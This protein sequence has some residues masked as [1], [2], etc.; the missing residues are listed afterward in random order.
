MISVAGV[1][2]PPMPVFGMPVMNYPLTTL[3]QA[4]MA[5][6]VMATV[7][8]RDAV[9]C[10][11][12]REKRQGLKMAL[13]K[14]MTFRMGCIDAAVLK[15]GLDH[16]GEP[17]T[18]NPA[19]MTE[20]SGAEMKAPATDIPGGLLIEPLVHEDERGVFFETCNEHAFEQATGLRPHFVQDN[21]AV[22]VPN[23][24][25]GL[26]YQV[27]IRQGKLVRVVRG[28]VFDVVVDRRRASP[29]FGQAMT[30]VLGGGNRRQ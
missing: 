16:D 5:I 7:S 18:E 12:M 25:R 21:Q 26:H 8:L 10:R 29:A 9:R 20:L 23:A 17:V 13:P 19:A 3:M 6:P 22:P 15:A 28:A 24:V 30:I 1:S 2:M 27:G 14:E 4:E 11:A